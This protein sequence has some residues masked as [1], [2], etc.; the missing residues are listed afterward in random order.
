MWPTTL[1]GLKPWRDFITCYSL[2][3]LFFYDV[4]HTTSFGLAVPIWSLHLYLLY[5]FVM[6]CVALIM[7]G[8]VSLFLYFSALGRGCVVFRIVLGDIIL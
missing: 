2:E 3:E 5:I 4:A 8:G 6:P 1:C 7:L